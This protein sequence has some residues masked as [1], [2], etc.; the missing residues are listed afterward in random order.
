MRKKKELWKL[1]DLPG[2]RPDDLDAVISLQAAL[3]ASKVKRS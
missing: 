2:L 3:D 1:H